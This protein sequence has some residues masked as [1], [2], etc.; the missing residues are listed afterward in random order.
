MDSYEINNVLVTLQQP[1]QQGPPR[2]DVENAHRML[3]SFSKLIRTNQHN[4]F[5]APFVVYHGKKEKAHTSGT[6][7]SLC[8]LSTS[9]DIETSASFGHHIY[10]IYVNKRFPFLNI[11]NA[12]VFWFIFYRL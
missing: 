9:L 10:R 11:G 12:Y 3:V 8:F 6:F 1:P 7:V 4:L 2:L 5:E